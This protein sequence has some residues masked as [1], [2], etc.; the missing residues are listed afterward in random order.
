MPRSPFAHGDAPQ[1]DFASQFRRIFEVTGCRTQAELAEFLEVKQSSISD[2]KRRQSVP[3]KWL[4][5]LFLKKRIN[6]DWVR[7]GRGE[8]RL[9]APEPGPDVASDAAPDLVADMPS[10]HGVLIER[11]PPEDCS[12]DELLAEVMRRVGKLTP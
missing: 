8:K 11:R 9:Y 10:A 12:T 4:F 3:M 5:K 6:P 1:S 2:A 7:L